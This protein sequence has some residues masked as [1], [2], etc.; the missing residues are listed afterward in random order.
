LSYTSKLSAAAPGSFHV[1]DGAKADRLRA[2]TLYI[3]SVADVVEEI[4][5]I[6]IGTVSDASDIRRKIA[7]LHGA[8][9]CCPAKFKSYWLW[10]AYAMEREGGEWLPW[11]RVTKNGAA[12]E[13]LP[14]GASAHSELMRAESNTH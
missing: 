4:R 7:N 14:G 9:V 13:Q 10:S 2:K 3:P 12:Y 6:P 5:K 1:L 11:W 8:D